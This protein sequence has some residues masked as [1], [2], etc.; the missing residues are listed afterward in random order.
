MSRGETFPG[1]VTGQSERNP[2]PAPIHLK[3]VPTKPDRNAAAAQP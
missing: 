3:T 1:D 2:A